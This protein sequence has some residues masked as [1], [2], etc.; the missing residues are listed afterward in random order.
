VKVA[1]PFALVAFV[2]VAAGMATILI[3]KQLAD[4]P[5]HASERADYDTL[6]ER[7]GGDEPAVRDELNELVGTTSVTLDPAD[8]AKVNAL[9]HECLDAKVLL[10]IG[11]T[12]LFVASRGEG[13]AYH[14]VGAEH[15]KVLRAIAGDYPSAERVIAIRKGLAQI[16]EGFDIVCQPPDWS[17]KVEG[18]GSPP[19]PILILLSET[20]RSFPPGE[21]LALRTNPRVPAFSATDAELL[22]QL[23][24]FW[25][26]ANVRAVL[27]PD[28]YPKLYKNRRIS[29]IPTAIAEYQEEFGAAVLAEQHILLP[30]EQPD[31]EGV[32]ALNE[33][34]GRLEQFLSAIVTFDK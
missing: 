17:I 28:R 21:H 31:P 19:L 25:N 14:F 34:Y 12:Q 29:P 18:E 23:E 9:K 7:L 11:H 27:T 22:I 5:G 20:H 24:R 6:V 1:H 16:A 15:H 26:G 33:V 32:Q 13:M 2:L 4:S 8:R 3:R 10:A 30:G